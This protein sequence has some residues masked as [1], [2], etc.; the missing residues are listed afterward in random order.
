MSYHATI[1]FKQCCLLLVLL[2]GMALT[3]TAASV[4]TQ[5][6]DTERAPSVQSPSA[7]DTAALQMAFRKSLIA[8]GKILNPDDDP[9]LGDGMA[10][11]WFGTAVAVAGD[12]AVIGAYRHAH[13]GVPGAGVAYVFARVSGQWQRQ[14]SLHASST[15]LDDFFGYSVAIDDDTIIVGAPGRKGPSGDRTGAAYVFTRSGQT[16]SEQA[17][18]RA[19][20]SDAGDSV[21]SSVALQGD[22]AFVGAF[23][24]DS[25]AIAQA[26]FVHVFL[27]SKGNWQQQASLSAPD[28]GAGDG[29]GWAIALSGNSVLIGAPFADR[30]GQSDAGAAYVFTEQTEGYSHQATLVASDPGSDDLFGMAVALYADTALVG[31]P[32][33][34]TAVGVDSGS[35][36][37]FLRSSGNWTRDPKLIASDGEATDFFGFSVVLDA[38]TAVIGAFSNST[39][40]GPDTGSAYVYAYEGNSWQEQSQ[41]RP[42]NVQSYDNFSWALALSGDELFA[43]A[44]N[45]DTEAGISA[46]SATVFAFDGSQWMEQAQLTA[47]NGA[48]QNQFGSSVVMAGDTALIS[49][50]DLYQGMVHVFVRQGNSWMRQATLRGADAVPFDAFGAALALDGDTALVS[51]PF[52]NVGNRVGSGA[53]YVFVRSQGIWTQQAKLLA[54]NPGSND[55]FGD[56][57]ALSGD[58]ALIG[59]PYMDGVSENQGAVVVFNRTGS[60]WTETGP[61]QDP[62][63]QAFGQFGLALALAGDLAVVGAPSR[64]SDT[65]LTG[66][67][68]IYRRVS[69][70]FSLDQDLIGPSLSPDSGFGEVVAL[71]G[72]TVL[73]GAPYQM[74]V[75][76]DSIGTVF[77]FE[78]HLGQFSYQQALVPNDVQPNDRFGQSL[79][80]AG[81]LA[82][83]GSQPSLGSM[84]PERE[85]GLAYVFARGAAGF[86]EAVKLQASDGEVGDAYGFSVALSGSSGLIGAPQQ[87]SRVT[88]SGFVG[89]VY[90]LTQPVLL[91]DGFEGP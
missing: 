63:G 81:D 3:P 37:V 91:S 15:G 11:D 6:P 35:A 52:Q 18:L 42:S 51:A 61:L 73:V 82:L 48:A 25:G 79:A 50:T 65:V 78:Q 57:L 77:V 10:E 34:D 74:N 68:Y 36:Y 75:S 47:G 86:S 55:A 7:A 59:G 21:G 1:S 12:T 31:A 80:L 19:N 27:R 5:F 8:D 32:A 70:S 14:T 71:S 67:A 64:F 4:L 76:G 66:R 24:G 43:S 83:I 87:N 54:S 84:T 40:S 88:D 26:G 29:F 22:H 60:T 16:W 20:N 58:T 23:A 46:G 13:Q 30:S 85:S 90:A 39:P 2:F 45:D 56:A 33:D 72:D 69:G 49:A 53:V 89:A 9:L 28:A 62:N 44:Y 41:L 17:I 38:D